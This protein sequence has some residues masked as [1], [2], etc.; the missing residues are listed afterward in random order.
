[1]LTWW[2]TVPQYLGILLNKAELYCSENKEPDTACYAM[3]N[4]KHNKVHTVGSRKTIFFLENNY[5]F[6]LFFIITFLQ[7]EMFAETKEIAVAKHGCICLR[8]RNVK[9]FG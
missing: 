5:Y 1:M 9:D 7:Q 6:Y 2:L 4:A 3:L 8:R